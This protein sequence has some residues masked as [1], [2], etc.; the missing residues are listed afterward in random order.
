MKIYIIY[1]EKRMIEPFKL[2]LIDT[3]QLCEIFSI[4]R[5]TLYRYEIRGDLPFIKIG[6]NHY[7][8]PV[9]IELFFKNLKQRQD[10]KLLEKAEKRR[11][12][13]QQEIEEN[14]QEKKTD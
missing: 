12:K 11:A 9:D 7:Y 14:R 10:V 13:K 6:S 8:R 4:S 3:N 2:Q 5:Q 1:K